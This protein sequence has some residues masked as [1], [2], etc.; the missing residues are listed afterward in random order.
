LQTPKKH[1]Q[2]TSKNNE[3]IYEN[4]NKHTIVYLLEH[5]MLTL[6]SY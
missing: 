6:S 3:N 5:N 4:Q 1:Q 2:K